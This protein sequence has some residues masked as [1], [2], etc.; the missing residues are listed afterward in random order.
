MNNLK[1][2]F[3]HTVFCWLRDNSNFEDVISL[4]RGLNELSKISCIR[5]AY[6][7]KPANTRREVIDSS[8]GFSITFIFENAEDQEAYQVHPDHLLFIENYSHLWSRVQVY[9]AT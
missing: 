5:E 8:F 7:G 3:V 4:E 6:I 2:G 9:D 1:K